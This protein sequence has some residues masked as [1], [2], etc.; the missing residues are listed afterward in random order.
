MLGVRG[1]RSIALGAA[2]CGA[3]IWSVPGVGS[4]TPVGGGR[5]CA[6]S[7]SPLQSGRVASDAV[8]VGCWDTPQEAELALGLSTVAAFALEQPFAPA[9]VAAAQTL[10]GRDYSSTGY[11]G[12]QQIWYANNSTGCST[13]SVYAYVMPASFDNVTRS[14]QGSGGCNNNRHYDPPSASGASILC[15]PN[16]S[17]MGTMAART[18][19][20]RWAP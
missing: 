2:I 4:S 10:I 16:C 13:G 1:A 9:A 12:S 19:F 8:V 7:L 6:T 17:S 3:A 11:L 15:A 5:T 14:V 20:V 18:S